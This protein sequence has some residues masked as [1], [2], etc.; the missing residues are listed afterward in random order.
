M[1][2]QNSIVFADQLMLQYKFI[3]LYTD[4]MDLKD[5]YEIRH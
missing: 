2:F 5:R 1:G 3:Y 4:L